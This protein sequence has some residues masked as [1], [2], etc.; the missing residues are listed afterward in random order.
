MQVELKPLLKRLNRYS[1][2]ALEGAAGLCVSRGHYEVSV[3]HVLLKMAAD[4]GA[5][6]ALILDHFDADPGRFEGALQHAVESFRSGNQGK[7]VFSPILVEWIQDAWML[8]SI[9]LGS[10]FDS[11]RGAGRGSGDAPGALPRR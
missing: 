7:P 3:E 4:P 10:R 6:L 11:L 2:A 1:T 9:E 8:A 5:D